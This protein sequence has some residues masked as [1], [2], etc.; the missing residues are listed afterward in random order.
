MYTLKCTSVFDSDRFHYDK[1]FELEKE[2]AGFPPFPSFTRS[3]HLLCLHL[4]TLWG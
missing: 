1:F 4:R 3:D 2:K